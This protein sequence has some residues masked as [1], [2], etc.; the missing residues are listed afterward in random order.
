MKNIVIILTLA[1][2]LTGAIIT[3]AQGLKGIQQKI[4]SAVEEAFMQNSLD[5]FTT[6]ETHLNALANKGGQH[7]VD[8]WK[9]YLEFQKSNYYANNKNPDHEE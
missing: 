6:V 9:A 4:D 5:G 1:A 3:K 8:Y 2:S 7:W